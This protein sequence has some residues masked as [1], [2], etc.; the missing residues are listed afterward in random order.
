MLKSILE[1]LE[2]IFAQNEIRIMD[3]SEVRHI[4]LYVILLFGLCS[5]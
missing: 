3:D 1:I 5:I 2:I 4:F